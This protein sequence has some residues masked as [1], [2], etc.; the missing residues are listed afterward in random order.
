MFS[1]KQPFSNFLEAAHPMLREVESLPLR[2]FRHT[3]PSHFPVMQRAHELRALWG[4]SGHRPVSLR[5][6]GIKN[7]GLLSGRSL[8]SLTQMRSTI[9]LCKAGVATKY[10]CPVAAPSIVQGYL[11][12]TQ[13]ASL[14]FCLSFLSSLHV[15]TPNHKEDHP[16]NHEAQGRHSAFFPGLSHSSLD[17]MLWH[18]IM[19]RTIA[20]LSSLSL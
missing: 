6:E 18:R 19:R 2:L 10:N 16:G 20:V 14:P 1:Q 15:L 13:E 17:S 11:C 12:C 9:E 4:L 5:A 3:Q 7:G 8:R